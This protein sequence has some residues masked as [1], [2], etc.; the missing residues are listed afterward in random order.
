MTPKVQPLPPDRPQ[1]T[2]YLCIK[3]AAKALDFYREAFGAKETQRMVD[4][5][6]K[7]GHAEIKIGNAWIMLSDEFPEWGATSPETLGGS[8]VMLHLYVEDV[9]RFVGRAVEAGARLVRPVEDQF[10]GD[11][12]G[13]LIDPFGHKWWIASKVEEVSPEEMKK[14]AEAL[15]G[16]S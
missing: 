5:S 15:Y 12:G 7:V 2:V 4:Q 9:D 14:R 3:D 10:Y 13:Q 6:G 11:R 8:P 16:M 1:F